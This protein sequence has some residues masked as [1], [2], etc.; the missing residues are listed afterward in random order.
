[1]NVSSVVMNVTT[2]TGHETGGHLKDGLLLGRAK[3]YVRFLP[4]TSQLLHYVNK[5]LLAYVILFKH[6]NVLQYFVCIRKRIFNCCNILM[7]SS[8]LIGTTHV[9][10][11]YS[12]PFSVVM[13]MCASTEGMVVTLTNNALTMYERT[14]S[15]Q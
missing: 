14:L 1:M 8:H 3:R 12:W 9:R 15:H 4:A 6:V 2:I 11:P 7:S 13:L 10:T 5:F